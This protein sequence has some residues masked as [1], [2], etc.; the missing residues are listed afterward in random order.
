MI[1]LFI[2]DIKYLSEIDYVFNIIRRI[3]NIDIKRV[4]EIDDVVE[5]DFLIY[6]GKNKLQRQRTINIRPSYLF[7]NVYM[8]KESIPKH[9]LKKYNNIPVIYSEKSSDISANWNKK[10]QQFCTNIDII[11]SIFFMLTRYEEI[12][13]WYDI[14]KDMYERFPATESLAYKEKFLNIPIVNEYIEW[15]WGWLKKIGYKGE[16][17]NFF[18]KNKLIACLTHDVDMPF[19]NIDNLK[20]MLKLFRSNKNTFQKYRNIINYA[21][22]KINYKKDSFFTF[23]YIRKIEKKYNFTSSFY[24]MSGGNTRY[25]NF[26]KVNDYRVKNLIEELEKDKCEVGYHYSFNAFDSISMRKNEKKSLDDIFKTK[27]YGGRNHY[28]RFNPAKSFLI[29][30][31]V[32]LLYDTT[33]SYADHEGFR[34]GIC[35][36]YKPYDIYKRK[37]IDIWEIPLIIME[38]TLKQYRKLNADEAYKRIQENI[39]TVKKYN[40]VF[41]ILWH[42][43]SFDTDEWS[44]WDIVFEKTMKYLFENNAVGISGR[45]VINMIDGNKQRNIL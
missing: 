8:K 22:S 4:K 12:I 25:D 44:G 23:D 27:S 30:Q 14:E 10:E 18:G 26:Y 40:G 33:L 3:L 19:K 32:G 20:T 45:Q 1:K 37:E 5:K 38:G 29:S 34:C 43:S 7:T 28:L 2:E 13:L 6:Y 24:F 17:S 16:R 21:V 36:P 41:T 11:Q 35:M 15:F 39:D 31:E 9:K 42:N